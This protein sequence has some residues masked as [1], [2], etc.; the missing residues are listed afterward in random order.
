MTQEKQKITAGVR[1]PWC[2]HVRC[3][4][5]SEDRWPKLA[6]GCCSCLARV[7]REAHREV[8]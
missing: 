2:E 3:A 7:L 8:C 5:C 1:C 6:D 4:Q